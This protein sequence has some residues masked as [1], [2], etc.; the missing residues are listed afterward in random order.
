MP[1]EDVVKVYEDQIVSVIVKKIKNNET[2]NEGSEEL[3][4]MLS[5]WTLLGL[6]RLA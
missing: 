6:V 3:E 4:N 5:T 1:V 2:W